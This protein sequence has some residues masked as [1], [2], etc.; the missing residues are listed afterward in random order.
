[1]SIDCVTPE[2]GPAVGG[3]L[4]TLAGEGYGGS[5]DAACAFPSLRSA[6]S[7]S[8]SE[9]TK[10]SARCAAVSDRRYWQSLDE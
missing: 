8:G 9:S 2:V 10:S 6:E 5:A 4:V 1:M 3:T 7:Q